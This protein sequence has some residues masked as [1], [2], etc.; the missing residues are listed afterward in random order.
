MLHTP[1]YIFADEFKQFKD[2]FLSHP[3]DLVLFKKGEFL[4]RENENLTDVYFILEG[5]IQFSC[6][7]ENGYQ[8]IISYYGK[9]SIFP[10]CSST[11]F[12]LEQSLVAVAISDVTAVHFS[13][14]DFYQMYLHHEELTVAV[15]ESYAKQVNLLLYQVA[16]QDYN[17]T[18]TK[19][20]NL[21]YLLCKY[22][23]DENYISITQDEIA[24]LLSIN[25]VNISKNISRLK[26][27]HVLETSRAY[28]HILDTEAL[29]SLCTSETID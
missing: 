19:I 9:N 23:S 5:L 29:S 27:L 10:G 16:H 21:L 28:I 12:R 14:T 22:H 6:L 7:H 17:N 24:Q 4:W 2:F 3:H 25:R 13:Q 18:L 8:K 20:C 1:S 15:L 11:K 26:Q